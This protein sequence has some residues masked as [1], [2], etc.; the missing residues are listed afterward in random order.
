MN[1]V[2]L[3]LGSNIGDSES[4]L[5]LA[6]KHI[7]SAVGTIEERSSLYRTA[8]WGDHDQPDFLNR[9]VIVKTSHPAEKVLQLILA[10][11][12]EM[13]RARTVKNAARIIDIDILFFNDAVIQTKDLTVPHR[14]IQNR[15][16]V[17]TPLTEVSPSF[18][19][20]VLHKKMRQLLTECG[21]ALNV[22]K[23]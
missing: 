21:D 11:E 10:A 3:L 23:I 15:R 22:Q 8:A 18:I 7:Q 12:K 19:H 6:E 9:V 2:Y 20:P 4:N 5:S 14:E 1:T 16:F 17:L 13:G